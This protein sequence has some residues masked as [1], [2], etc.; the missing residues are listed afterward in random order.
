M[1]DPMM[2]TF[3][4]DLTRYFLRVHEGIVQPP[5][6]DPGESLVDNVRRLELDSGVPPRVE[7]FLNS[8]PPAA[9]AAVVAAVGTG[10]ASRA[11]VQLAW[12]PAYAFEVAITHVQRDAEMLTVVVKSPFAADVVSTSD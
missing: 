11:L 5:A 10:L 1:P 8:M 9:A 4:A 12:L 3:S 6:L 7:E 2:T